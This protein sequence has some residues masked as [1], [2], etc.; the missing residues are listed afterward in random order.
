[1]PDPSTPWTL[2]CRV[3]DQ[4]DDPQFRERA[5]GI[6]LR[7]SQA[8]VESVL[9]LKELGLVD[10]AS[11]EIRASSASTTN[12]TD[13][14]RVDPDPTLMKPSPH[15]VLEALRQLDAT[16]KSAVM[17][18]DS[19]SDIYSARHAGIHSIGYANKPGKNYHLTVA[20]ADA[21]AFDMARIDGV[22]EGLERASICPRIP[23]AL[24]AAYP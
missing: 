17:I 18:G 16:R 12:N 19:E 1:V 24:Q 21:I 10:K 22:P 14:R 8:I 13:P 5:R 2:P 4:A 6:L 3:E 9:E 11:A 7:H 15:L 20:G 23:R